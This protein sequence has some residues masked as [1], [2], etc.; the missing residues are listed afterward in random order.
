MLYLVLPA[1]NEEE[2]VQTLLTDIAHTL[3][4]MMPSSAVTAVVVNDGSADRTAELVLAVRE[5]LHGEF[6]RFH[7][8]LLQHEVNKGLAEAIKSGLMYCVDKATPRDI[9]LTMDCDNSHTPGL[10]PRLARSIFEG[11]DVIIASRY[12]SGARI[13]GLSLSRKLLSAVASGIFR[14]IFPIP[15]VRDYT[16]G[17]RAYRASVLIDVFRKNPDLITETGFT[18]MIDL[19][20]KLYHADPHLAFGEVPLL[21]RYDRKQG[22]SKMNV[23]RTTMQTLHLLA[24]RRLGNWTS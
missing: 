12:V 9:I 6:P 5:Q 22:I 21:L 15:G 16:C 2:N 13:F 4:E 14:A 18:V 8:E 24:R 23:R 11:Y 7:V 20:L 1:Y 3:A 17:F 10:I 19:L